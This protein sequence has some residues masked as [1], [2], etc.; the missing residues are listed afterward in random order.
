MNFDAESTGGVLWEPSNFNDV[1]LGPISIKE[2]LTKSQNMVSIG[3][4]N[5]SIHHLHKVTYEGS[6]SKSPETSI[7]YFGLRSRSSYAA[8]ISG[9][10]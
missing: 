8:A 4:L 7:F 3:S 1:Y 5:E 9:R 6:V 2:A 10:L